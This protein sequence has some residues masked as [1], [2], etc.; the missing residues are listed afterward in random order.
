M[1]RM[2]SFLPEPPAPFHNFD[3]WLRTI[4]KDFA[5]EI[6]LSKN[7]LN[8]PYFNPSYINEIVELHMA[9]RANLYARLCSLITF[10]IW[11]RLFLP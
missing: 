10:E 11:H 1:G 5:V 6:L 4:L 2:I 7:L 9:G 8:R 3:Y